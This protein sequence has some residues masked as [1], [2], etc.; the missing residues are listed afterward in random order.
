MAADYPTMTTAEIRSAYLNFFESK[1]CKLYPSSSLV[2]DDPSLLLANAGMNQFKEFYQ[3][4]KTMKE[5][6]ACSCQKCVRTND[7]DIIGSDGRHASFFEML[8]NFAFGG[9]TKEQA[10]AW[11]YELITEVFKLPKDRLYFTVFTEDDETESV[12]RAL[13]VPADHIT[14]LGEDDN[15]WAAGPTGPCGP[16]SEN[17]LR[18]GRGGRLWLRHLRARVRLR[19][20]PGVLEPRVHAVRS[21]GGRLHA[22]AAPSQPRYRHGPGAHG[23]H[24]AAQE[25]LLRR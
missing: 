12:W 5:I 10:C 16:C 14:R 13:G 25:L 11:A 22:R 21:P 6:G 17:L 9:V 3:G 19:P 24:H 15:F 4:K 18:P 23:R 20:L 2:P 1:G 7:I 8:G